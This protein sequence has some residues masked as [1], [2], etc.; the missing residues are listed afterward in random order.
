MTSI[1]KLAILPQGTMNVRD[2]RGDEV[3][4]EATGEKW[5]ITFH[6]PGTKE[7][8]KALH[9]FDTAR[10]DVTIAAMKGETKR[11]VEDEAKHTA[12]FLADV[13]ISLNGFDYEGRKG[14]EANKAMYLDLEIGHIAKDAN[15]YLG[16][17]GNFLPPKVPTLSDTSDTQLG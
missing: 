10:S 11:A 17:R 3:T 5:S 7:Y 6:S 12:E 1:K 15:R 9:K 16:D 13:T 4:D 14:H 2:A 8:Q